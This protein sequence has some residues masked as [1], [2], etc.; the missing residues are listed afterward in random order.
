MF[1]FG[2]IGQSPTVDV[3]EPDR[4]S[5]QCYPNPFNPRV[6]IAY[7]MPRRG[8]L[9]VKIYNLRG[10]LVRTLIDDQVA[11]GD[12]FVPWDGTD[13]SGQIVASGVYFAE[14]QALGEV[15]VDKLALVK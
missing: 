5:V 6:K 4:F 13:S 8:E 10:E 3:P 12:G 15:H 14:T 11:A 1:A 7:H 2:H 9:A